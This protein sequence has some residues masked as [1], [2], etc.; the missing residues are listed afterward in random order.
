MRHAV[1]GP[2]WQHLWQR[3]DLRPDSDPL[4]QVFDVVIGHADAAVGNGAPDGARPVGSVDGKIAVGE[5]HCG[6]S[7]RIVGGSTRDNIR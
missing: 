4:K 6:R 7:H 2:D 5:R 1:S 3:H